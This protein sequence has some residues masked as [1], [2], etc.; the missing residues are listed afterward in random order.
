MVTKK[1]DGAT[2]FKGGFWNF[3]IWI[4]RR[5]LLPILCQMTCILERE[6]KQNSYKIIRKRNYFSLITKFPAKN[7]DL[8]ASQ[9]TNKKHKDSSDVQLAQSKPKKKSPAQ[10]ARDRSRR[11]EF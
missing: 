5:V 2:I 1:V 11:K 9:H 8:L 10:V 6:E 7:G 3:K 4:K